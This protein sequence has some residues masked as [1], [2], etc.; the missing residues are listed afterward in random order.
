MGRVCYCLTAAHKETPGLGVWDDAKSGGRDSDV[1]CGVCAE[2]EIVLMSCCDYCD[3]RRSG[4][5]H[6]NERVLSIEC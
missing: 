4:Y 2:K 3:A 6:A 5:C 1:F